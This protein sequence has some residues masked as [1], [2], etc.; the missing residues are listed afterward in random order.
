M[1]LDHFI[2]KTDRDQKYLESPVVHNDIMCGRFILCEFA[3][4]RAKNYYIDQV[5]EKRMKKVA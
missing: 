4:K 1:G 3:T 2:E 5:I